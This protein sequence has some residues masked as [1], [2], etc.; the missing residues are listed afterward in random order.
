MVWPQ[1]KFLANIDVAIRKKPESYSYNGYVVGYEYIF[2]TQTFNY[3]CPNVFQHPYS[4]Y[5]T[6]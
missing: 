3:K 5:L 1:V 6:H 4:G 2:N